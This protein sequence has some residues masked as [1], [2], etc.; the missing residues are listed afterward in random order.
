MEKDFFSYYFLVIVIVMGIF[1]IIAS[2]K[3]EL[4]AYKSGI[5]QVMYWVYSRI[6]FANEWDIFYCT[7][8]LVVVMWLLVNL[9]F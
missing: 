5:K 2:S 6:A 8:L 9:I 4:E 7:L 1:L 3:E